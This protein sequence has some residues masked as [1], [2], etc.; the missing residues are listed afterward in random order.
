MSKDERVI[1]GIPGLDDMLGGGFIPSPQLSFAA[2]PVQA[3][4]RSA[5]NI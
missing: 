1:S 2:H 5:C 4:Q 3:K